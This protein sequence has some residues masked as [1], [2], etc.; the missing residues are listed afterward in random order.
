MRRALTVSTPQMGQFR[1]YIDYHHREYPLFKPIA[2]GAPAF[3]IA[4]WIV[5]LRQGSVWTK[6]SEYKKDLL[7]SW[8]RR[9]GTGYKWDF[10][11]ELKT[12]FTNLPDRAE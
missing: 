7:R 9:L 3:F 1:R 10:G 8:R 11:P 2:Y 5:Y 12:V 4:F 6:R